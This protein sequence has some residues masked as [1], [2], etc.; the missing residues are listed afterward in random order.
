MCVW[1]EPIKTN[2]VGGTLRSNTLT[3]DFLCGVRKKRNH[4]VNRAGGMCHKHTQ[5]GVHTLKGGNKGEAVYK[6]NFFYKQPDKSA[7]EE[8][9]LSE[10]WTNTQ[11][12]ANT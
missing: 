4:H 9:L 5:T 6:A 11:I 7:A 3:L 12:G 8:L 10:P 2:L 1:A